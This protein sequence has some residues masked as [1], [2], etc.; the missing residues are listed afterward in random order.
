MKYHDYLDAPEKSGGPGNFM[1]WLPF[2][3]TAGFGLLLLLLINKSV[4]EILNTKIDNAVKSH[5]QLDMAI[6]QFAN[7][8]L[9]EDGTGE[10]LT[11]LVPPVG[12]IIAY[13]GSKAPS[14]WVLCDGQ[15]FSKLADKE[16][17]K[18]LRKHL[19]DNNLD[20]TKVPDLRG[21]FLRGLSTDTKIDPN[22]GDKKSEP[23]TLGSSQADSNKIHTHTILNTTGR[24]DHKPKDADQKKEGT[25]G[26]W[27]VRQRKNIDGPNARWSGNFSGDEIVPN[28]VFDTSGG[29]H[30]HEINPDGMR[31]TR[32]KNIAV[33]Y[34]IKY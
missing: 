19:Q 24:H 11:T 21:M 30:S 13:Y 8:L 31:E 5:G 3:L 32:P 4:S 17:Y 28:K 23:R 20:D 1:N 33:N 34:L 26:G 16:K 10:R 6:N 14:G 12:T 25:S 18:K 22:D 29:E 27:L 2:I 9:N 7:G 15:P